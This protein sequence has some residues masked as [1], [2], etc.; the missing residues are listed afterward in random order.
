MRHTGVIG[1]GIVS[2][3]RNTGL[4]T[5]LM[6]AVI[7]WAR[8]HP[9]LELLWLQVYADNAAGRAL[10]QKMGFAETGLIRDFCKHGDRYHD[11]I[12]MSLDLP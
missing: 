4:G 12:T 9:V 3:W 8:Q 10:Y 11:M 6:T 5:A 7:D 2:A 1:M